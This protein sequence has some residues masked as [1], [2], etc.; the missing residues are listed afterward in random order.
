MK[1]AVIGASTE[2]GSIIVKSLECRG[3]STVVCVDELTHLPG[4]GRVVIKPYADLVA[5]DIRDV[6]AV[7]DALSFKAL[8]TSG[9]ESLPLWHVLKLIRGQNIKCLALGSVACLYEDDRRLSY[10]A[11]D[12]TLCFDE[13]GA[14]GKLCKKALLRLKQLQDIDWTLLCPP[15]ICEDATH[16]SGH[17]EFSNDVLPIGMDGSSVISQYDFCDAAAEIIKQGLPARQVISVRQIRGSR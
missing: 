14:S 10:I 3:I 16:R 12:E 17:Y 6:Y 11:D 9:F 5:D 7:V 2:W 1:V 4:E 8:D 13:H 15:L